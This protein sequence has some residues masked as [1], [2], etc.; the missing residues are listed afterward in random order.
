MAQF[1]TWG[2]PTRQQ[3]YDRKE[4]SR[5]VIKRASVLVDPCHCFHGGTNTCRE[6][7]LETSSPQSIKPSKQQVI[8]WLK[9]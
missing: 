3:K 2:Y 8:K 1:K 6:A 4:F 7:D 5:D 9:A